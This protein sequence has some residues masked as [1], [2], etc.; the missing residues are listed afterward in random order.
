M[1]NPLGVDGTIEKMRQVASANPEAVMSILAAD[2]IEIVDTLTGRENAKLVAEIEMLRAKVEWQEDATRQV[3]ISRG[4]Y[5]DKLVAAEAER[6]SLRATRDK[7]TID[8]VAWR[9]RA[10]EMEYELDK[11]RWALREIIANNDAHYFSSLYEAIEE[12]AKLL[13]ENKEIT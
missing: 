13:P 3:I 4:E 9:N 10:V 2:L 7:Y 5:M 11:L 1:R 6:D 12:A 8:L